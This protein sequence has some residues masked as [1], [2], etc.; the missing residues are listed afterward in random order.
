MPVLSLR[1]V[2]DAAP[3]LPWLTALIEAGS[4]IDQGVDRAV[5]LS[6]RVPACR[7]GCHACCSQPIPVSTIETQG[8]RWFALSHLNGDL[9]R[10]VGEALTMQRQAPC[11]F[12]VDGAC[13]V[14][15]MRPL[16]CR[17]YIV[18]NQPCRLGE[19]P[20][21]TRPLDVLPLA[22]TAQL[23]AFTVL[24]PFYG[25]R[26][27]AARD[28]ALQNRLVL[29]DTRILQQLDWQGLGSALCGK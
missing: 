6:G 26:G 16:A 8:L 11:P 5:A 10:K 21:Q 4:I 15:P 19:R 18:F 22:R 28:E 24:L 9:A 27:G 12:L 1:R 3:R 29:R 14:Y 20:E 13:A 25:V 2:R 23:Q 17:E 7:A